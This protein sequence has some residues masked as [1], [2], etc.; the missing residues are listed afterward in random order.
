MPLK[1]HFQAFKSAI[2]EKRKSKIASSAGTTN[3]F[4]DV[5]K[6]SR[7][8]LPEPTSTLSTAG[9]TLDPRAAIH[10]VHQEVIDDGAKPDM[11]GLCWRCRVIDLDD[12]LM[13]ASKSSSWRDYFGVYD[14]GKI[15]CVSE[16]CPVCQFFA[17]LCNCG[18]EGARNWI[19]VYHGFLLLSTHGGESQ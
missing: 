19:V 6:H 1:D 11:D 4:A 7:K 16:T 14:L 8:T 5:Q 10:T 17:V 15:L 18:K 12:L 13:R 3:E 9:H 2:K